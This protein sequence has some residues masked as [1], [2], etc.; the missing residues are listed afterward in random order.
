MTKEEKDELVVEILKV[1]PPS[2]PVPEVSIKCSLSSTSQ[3]SILSLKLL[4]TILS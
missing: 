4:Y 1:F 3:V 2:P